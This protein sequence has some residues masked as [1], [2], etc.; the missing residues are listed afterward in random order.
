MLYF[1]RWEGTNAHASLVVDGRDEEHARE[2]A[3]EEAGAEPDSATLMPVG[4]FAAEVY[5]DDEPDEDGSAADTDSEDAVL[6]VDPFDHTIDALAA[7]ENGDAADLAEVIPIVEVAA[8]GA[9]ATDDEN[10][11]V[12]CGLADGHAG[13]H[14]AGDLSW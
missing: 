6:V 12:S 4:V 11:V 5:F 8:C 3:N 2:I 9:E 13:A 1:C 10:R 7:L 14:R